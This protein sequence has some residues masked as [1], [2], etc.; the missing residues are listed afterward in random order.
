MTL[1]NYRINLITCEVF[2]SFCIVICKACVLSSVMVG[3]VSQFSE[4]LVP[5]WL[6]QRLVQI[7]L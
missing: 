3:F 7:V 4:A 6:G 2:R 5:S 1:L